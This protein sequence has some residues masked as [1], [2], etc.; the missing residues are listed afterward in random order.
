MPLQAAPA[1]RHWRDTV[2]DCSLAGTAEAHL[3]CYTENLL[4]APPQFVVEGI[5]HTEAENQTV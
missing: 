3:A 4:T 1:L 5:Q 2:T